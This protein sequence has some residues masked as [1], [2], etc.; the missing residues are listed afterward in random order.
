MATLRGEMV[1]GIAGRRPPGSP[2][3]VGLIGSGRM[4][5]V[6]ASNLGRQP[7]AV[8]ASVAVSDAGRAAGITEQFRVPVRRRWQDVVDDPEVDA[9]VMASATDLHAEQIVAAS[10]AGKDVFCEKPVASGL[11]DAVRA[12]RAAEDAGIVLHVGFQRRHDPAF[13]ALRAEVASGRIG[14][15]WLLRISSRDPEPPPAHFEGPCGGLFVDMAIHDFDMA[16]FL[17]GEEVV[18]VSSYAQVLVADR[19]PPGSE[20]DVAVTTLVFGSGALGVIENCRRSAA[21]Y[22]QR[23]EVHG[24]SGTLTVENQPRH[25]LVVSD[26]A[27][28][29]RPPW[30]DFFADRYPVA[31]A[32]EIGAFVEE[33]SRRRDAPQAP[34]GPG[35]S[36]PASRSACGPDGARALELALAADRSARERRPV[37]VS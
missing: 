26:A 18:E 36:A 6:H 17:L 11:E 7:G 28:A 33:V 10:K 3:R 13:S 24:R 30:P 21:G 2:L 27:G 29:H 1:E 5:L 14:E 12:V 22:D 8:L 25:G 35:A 20:P 16:R 4:A 31:Y 37:N 34:S 15:P 9:L 32:R 19:A 23:V